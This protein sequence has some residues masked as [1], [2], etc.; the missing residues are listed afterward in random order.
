MLWGRGKEGGKEDGVGSDEEQEEEEEEGERGGSGTG[1][2]SRHEKMREFSRMDH[3]SL[4][5][6]GRMDEWRW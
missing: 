1:E 6:A 4:W 3:K 5:Y 2:G